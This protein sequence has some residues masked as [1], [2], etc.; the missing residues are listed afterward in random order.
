[1]PQPILRLLQSSK[2]LVVLTIIIGAF[3]AF[4][5]GKVT[6]DEATSLVKWVVGP[7]LL[8]QGAEDAAKHFGA[9]K[10]ESLGK[11][12]YESFVAASL[13]PPAL[14]SKPA[15]AEPKAE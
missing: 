9:S 1:M 13:P 4:Q 5:F 6:W 11:A 3:L 10:G 8:A 14:D 7:W 2:A 12:A 15:K